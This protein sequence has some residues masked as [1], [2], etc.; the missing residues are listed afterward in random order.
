MK[1]QTIALPWISL[2]LCGCSHYYYVSN[3]QNVPLFREKNEYRLNAGYGFGDET[4]CIEVQAA[5]AV[6]GKI[7]ITGNFMTVRGGD[8]SDHDYGK[9]N[10]FDGGIGYYLP[11]KDFFSFEIYSGIG[12]S[13]QHHEYSSL[14]Y[15]QGSLNSQN[16]GTSDLSFIKLFIQPAIGLKHNVFE[17]A[18][19]TRLSSVSYTNIENYAYSDS[20]VYEELNA[21]SGKMHFFLEP[22]VTLRIGWKSLKLQFQ[23]SYS[24]YL[25][26]PRMYFGEEAHLSAGIYFAFKSKNK[27]QP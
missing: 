8:V 25:N 9:G 6:S 19:S 27:N 10:Y 24:G 12:G 5:Y 17:V 16:D 14:K 23:G 4:E 15:S 21:I 13:S 7:G 18:V 26:S 11:V 2:F 1:I 3:V 22:A 20:H